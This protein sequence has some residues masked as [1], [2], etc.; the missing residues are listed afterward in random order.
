VSAQPNERLLDGREMDAAVEE[1]F[2][3]FR[4]DPQYLI[5]MARASQRI[6]TKRS[7]T[8]RKNA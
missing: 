1:A 2:S 4:S 5:A 6:A 7:S 8:R 3:A